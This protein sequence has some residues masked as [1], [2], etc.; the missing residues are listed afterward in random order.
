MSI[1]KL[2]SIQNHCCECSDVIKVN[3]LPSFYLKE[4]Q[5]GNNV[6]ITE[7]PT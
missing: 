1:P 2:N 6:V 7:V 5:N 3:F 4:L